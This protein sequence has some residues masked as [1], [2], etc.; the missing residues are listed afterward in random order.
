MSEKPQNMTKR[1]GRMGN[2]FEI[3]F[4]EEI[5]IKLMEKYSSFLDVCLNPQTQP[6]VFL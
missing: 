3:F 6:H 2:F 1:K 4:S 5:T